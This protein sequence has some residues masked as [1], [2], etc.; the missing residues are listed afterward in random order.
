[1]FAEINSLGLIG[2]NSFLVSTEIEASR[3]LPSFDIVGCADTAVRESRERIKSA[4]R[5]SGFRFPEEQIIIN[6]A[7]AD[8]KKTGSVHD[9]AILVA[10]FSVMGFV[11]ADDLRDCAFVGEVSLGGD[12]RPING[13]LPMAIMAKKS[14]I[15]HFFVP[16]ENGKEASVCDGI[17]VYP[18]KCLRELYDHFNGKTIPPSP[19]YIPS[20]EEYHENLDYMDVKGQKAAK[21]ALEIAASGGHNILMIGSPGSGKSMLAKR[22][23]SIL[24]KMTFDESVET[25]NVHS[26]AGILDS[27]TPL[28][29]ERPFRSP[30]H[31]ISSVGLSGGGTV[32]KPGEI[33][34]AHNG[35]L[36]LDE[37]AEFDRPTLEVLRQ[38]LEDRQV[39]ISRAW[40]TVTYPS[41]IMLVVAMNPCPCGYYGHPTKKCTCTQR[42][43]NQYMS[44]ISGPL[45]D[46]IDI[47]VE[48]PPVEFEDISSNS[49]EESSAEIRERVQ[50]TREIQNARFKGT[51]ITCNAQI[52]SDII[53]DVCEMTNSAKTFLKDVFEKL[54]LS[55]RGYDR[56]LK[57]ARTA[58]DMTGADLIDKSHI[59]AAV[60]YRSLDRKYFG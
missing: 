37:L 36:F 30:H 34:L 3:G 44:R 29:C 39:T 35:V 15:K 26:I 10:L 51:K 27:K 22:L 41:S 38:P 18:V 16:F 28:V 24:P 59:A 25:T 19:K 31:T 50:R 45:L 40:G 60:S 6:L 47:Q 5:S 1:M 48:V 17:S 7:P 46:R 33:S 52:T 13:A 57:V 55:A 23:P 58:A 42:K 20:Y 53:G 56:I 2:M 12:I 43:V 8:T 11:R 21:K 4:F 49:K 54:G 14:G 9:L 32:P